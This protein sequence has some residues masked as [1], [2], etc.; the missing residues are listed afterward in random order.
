[1]KKKY[2]PGEHV[3]ESGIYRV[4]HDSHRLM[5]EATLTRG[6]RFPQCLQCR[7]AVRFELRR[8]VQAPTSVSG[9]QAILEDYPDEQTSKP[10]M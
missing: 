1:M 2:R 9:H 3:P 10:A 4:D 5:H 6:V 8:A 7:D